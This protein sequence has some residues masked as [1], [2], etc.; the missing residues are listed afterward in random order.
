MSS[1][2]PRALAAVLEIMYCCATFEGGQLGVSV[3]ISLT[4][5]EWTQ[6]L[7]KHTEQFWADLQLFKLEENLW[8]SCHLLSVALK[9]IHRMD[10]RISEIPEAEGGVA[11]RCHHEALRGVRTAMRELLVVPCSPQHNVSGQQNTAFHFH[12][13]LEWNADDFFSFSQTKGVM[14]ILNFNPATAVK[15]WEC[16]WRQNPRYLLHIQ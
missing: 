12:I 6:H 5:Q 9:D 1:S 14:V 11:G 7:K 3:E 2:T 13:H 15:V 16:I 8:R 10:R 4:K